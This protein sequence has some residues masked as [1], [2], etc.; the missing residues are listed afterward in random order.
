M[1]R[2]ISGNSFPAIR[3]VQAGAEFYTVMCPLKRLR[4]IFTFDEGELPVSER[5][6]RILNPERI[7]EI[8]N[9]ILNERDAYVFSA[10]TACIEGDSEFTPIGDMG[11]QQKIGTL[12]I[13]EDA[14]VFITDGQHRNAAIL[15]ALKQDPTLSNETITVVFFA[16]KSLAER[17]K[18]FK[19]LNLYPVKTDS[20]L[21]IT[22]DDK[23]A[24]LLS[25]TVIYESKILSKLIHMEKTNLGQRSKKLVSHSALNKATCELFDKIDQNTYTDQIPIAKEYWESVVMAIPSLKLVYNEQVSGGEVREENV[26]AYSVT[27]QAL[28]AV[29]KWLLAND[30]EWKL[31]LK[32]LK[33]I[34]WSRTNKIDW[35]G[36]CIVNG[37]MR[38][39]S[40]AVKLTANRIKKH[41]NI[42]LNNK[43]LAEEDKLND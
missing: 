1:T 15:E 22:Y 8:T 13:D 19:D 35:E 11:H 10:L 28:G 40:I 43:E 41:L 18:I 2:I 32:K 14:E 23:P 12:T 24:A 6:Q 31:R 26:L 9:Y 33:D 25:K 7:P 16:D 42:P 34:D 30:S 36:R 4:K 5:A 3:G 38:N 17:Q 29:G 21:S 39:S 37:A 20:S 27:F